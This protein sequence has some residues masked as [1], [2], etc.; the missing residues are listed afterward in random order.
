MFQEDI[1]VEFEK[2]MRLDDD[3]D[4]FDDVFDDGEEDCDR[5]SDNDS[6]Y[7]SPIQDTVYTK[8]TIVWDMQMTFTTSDRLPILTDDHHLANPTELPGVDDAQQS[9]HNQ[10]SGT[11]ITDVPLT[12]IEIP[13]DDHGEPIETDPNINLVVTDPQDSSLLMIDIRMSIKEYARCL[14]SRPTSLKKM[15]LLV[16]LTNNISGAGPCVACTP[17]I[18]KSTRWW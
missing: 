9:Q 10:T 2:K 15:I 16:A 12:M 13:D 18:E 5:S 6:V 11:A 1:G 8:L 14:I 7:R 17:Y 4:V 3:N